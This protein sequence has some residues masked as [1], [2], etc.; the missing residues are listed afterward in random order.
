MLFFHTVPEDFVGDVHPYFWSAESQRPGQH[1][2]F[3]RTIEFSEVQRII[4]AENSGE[5]LD[6]E[7]RQ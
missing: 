2:N 3:A 6:L 5:V 7:P 1:E 4:L